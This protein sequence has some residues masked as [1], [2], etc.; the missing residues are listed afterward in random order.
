M[1]LSIRTNSTSF[2]SL[3]ITPSG[4]TA[5]DFE[6]KNFFHDIKG[7]L[8]KEQIKRV[9]DKYVDGILIGKPDE[10]GQFLSVLYI[11]DKVMGE[12]LRGPFTIETPRYSGQHTIKTDNDQIVP[13]N[14]AVLKDSKG[15]IRYFS[16][17][18]DIHA[19]RFVNLAKGGHPSS[20]YDLCVMDAMEKYYTNVLGDNN[21]ESRDKYI[22]LV[23]LL[24]D[25]YGKPLHQIVPDIIREENL[26]GMGREKD[27]YKIDNLPDYAFCVIRD[28][29][30][31]DKPITPF[32]QCFQTASVTDS[33]LPI[34]MNNNGM[35]IKKCIDGK[36]HSIPNWGKKF[37]GTE[38]LTYE[39]IKYFMHSLR[40]ISEFPALSYVNLARA[41]Q[42]LN[43]ECIRIDTI[44]PNNIL[45][46][47]DLQTIKIIDFGSE[48]NKLPLGIERPINGL[49]DM[50]AVLCDSLM[51]TR[52]YD[53]AT[54]ED[55]EILDTYAKNI[56]KKCG[57]AAK[58]SNIGNFPL[59]TELY[60]TDID[61]R[62][63]L[64]EGGTRLEKLKAFKKHF[65]DFLS[66]D[67]VSTYYDQTLPSI[68]KTVLKM[69]E[70]SFKFV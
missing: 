31:P 59:N 9:N 13:E 5:I 39:D 14:V 16:F 34:M 8:K 11:K 19:R 42:K 52:Y 33:D 56:I 48:D 58:V 12:S 67:I 57:V 6:D 65:K 28:K 60:V 37:H 69:T 40:E 43:A 55:K 26:L 54:D 63:P 3:Y 21:A 20:Y 25:K 22:D 44:N 30:D 46:D 7:Y 10:Y 45:I 49:S 1:N 23:L 4:Q 64:K 53:M 27:V 41:L 51:Y 18:D 29:Y 50:E 66:K 61:E 68:K 2:K 24:R 17:K 62:I 15:N 38:P 32:Y 35:Y 70:S 47:K 36:S